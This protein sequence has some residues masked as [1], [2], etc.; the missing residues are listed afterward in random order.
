LETLRASPEPYLISRSLSTYDPPP[1]IPLIQDRA[2]PT[3]QHQALGIRYRS[4]PS[5]VRRT[6]TC[7]VGPCLRTIPPPPHGISA[8]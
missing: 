8:A 2:D 7:W 5:L 3:K 4:L 1:L 6:V